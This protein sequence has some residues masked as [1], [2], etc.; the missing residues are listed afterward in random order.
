MRRFV[1][2]DQLEVRVNGEKL[3]ALLHLSASIRS[4]AWK[5]DSRTV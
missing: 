5:C 3:N 2:W 1:E 4:S